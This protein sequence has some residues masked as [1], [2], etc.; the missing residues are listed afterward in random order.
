MKKL[1][2]IALFTICLATN[3]HS[4]SIIVDTAITEANIPDSVNYNDIFVH[5]VVINISGPT[6]Y[7]GPVYLLAGVDSSAGVLSVDTVSVRN[8]TNKINDTINFNFNETYNNANAY[9]TGGNVVVIWPMAPTLNTT[10]TFYTNVYVRKLVGI[11]ENVELYNA[12]NIYPNP[13]LNYIYIDK[14]SSE[15]T[16]KRVRILSSN[17]KVMYNEK[18]KGR[19]DI[20]KYAKG[21]YFLNIELDNSKVLHYKIIKTE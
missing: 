18:F 20:S 4:Q 8:V 7:T 12:F 21:I 9:R 15:K 17:G 2:I 6:P 5:T 13:S 19:I 16:I 1:I 3:V 10:D 14:T 11:N